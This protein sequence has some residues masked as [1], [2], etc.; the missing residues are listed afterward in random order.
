MTTADLTTRLRPR[1]EAQ[2]RDVLSRHAKID[3]H[4]HNADRTLPQDWS[5]LAQVLENDEVLEALDGS[6]RA[7]IDAIRVALHRMDEGTYGS[8]S[9]CGEA[10]RSA[11]LEALPFV[12]TCIGCASDAS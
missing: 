4:L 12:G 7:E 10:I 2:L 6:S 1:L 3:A 8:C 11:R 5:D 9:V